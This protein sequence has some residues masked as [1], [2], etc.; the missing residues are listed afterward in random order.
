MLVCHVITGLDNGG[1]ESALFRLCTAHV[2]PQPRH[3]VISLMSGGVYAERLERA[4]IEVHSLGMPRGKVT[5]RGLARCYRLL[6]ELAPDIV[7]TWMYHADLI[8]GAIASV[9]VR[10]P[11]VWGVRHANLDP[12]LHSKSTLRV[13]SLCALLSRWIPSRIVTCSAAA[14]A[15]HRAAGYDVSKFTVIPNGYPFASFFEQPEQRTSYRA[16]L[17]IEGG[18]LVVGMAAR[19]H[20]LK[21]HEALFEALR[22]LSDQ[23]LRFVC[24]LAGPDMSADNALLEHQL[25]AQGL[26]DRVRLLGPL[27]HLA[28]FMN[29]IDLHVLSS[30]S[31]SFPNVL[32]E[33]MACGTPCVTTD[34]GDAGAIVGQ[35]GWV[36]AP[37]DSLAL[38]EAISR[39]L[40]CVREQPEDW[41]ALRSRCGARIREHFSID[42][43]SSAYVSLWDEL[44]APR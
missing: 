15:V 40:H 42:R 33:A 44:L 16:A 23:G 28:S 10:A 36:V 27:D 8:G 14:I 21:N 26:A 4:G 41:R 7:Q 30:V 38:A 12:T 39:A 11:V 43:M 19:H 3:I 37:G 20:P 1:A 18:A 35:D 25:R 2:N 29:A 31:E 17:G 32:A 13:V 22:H 34:V 6:G 9:C 24:L 5:L